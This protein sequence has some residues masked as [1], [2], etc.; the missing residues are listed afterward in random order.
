M[1]AVVSLL[2]TV[3]IDALKYWKESIVNLA[4]ATKS[5]YLSSL[6]LFC[7]YMDMGPDALVSYAR[8]TRAQTGDP[9]LNQVLESRVR[10]WIKVLLTE[11]VETSTHPKQPFSKGSVVTMVAGVKS[12]FSCNLVPI[13]ISIRDLPHSE[14]EGSRCPEKEEILKAVVAA[15]RA[16]NQA[17]KQYQSTSS[18]YSRKTE[19]RTSRLIN[20]KAQT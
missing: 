8:E 17:S 15:A 11:G 4:D 2:V 14:P 13:N 18:S 5:S 12:F 10:A 3:E 20:E 9:R 1:D 19:R 7:D 16:K 6:R